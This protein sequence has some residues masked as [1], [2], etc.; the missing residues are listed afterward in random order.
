MAKRIYISS[1]WKSIHPYI[2][3]DIV[4]VAENVKKGT[5]LE[6][7]KLSRECTED[8]LS[9]QD[10]L[11]NQWLK[12][13]GL[14][15][16]PFKSDY[17]ICREESLLDKLWT[18]EIDIDDFLGYPKCCV[19]NHRQHGEKFLQYLDDK[20]H[21]TELP[22]PPGII[23]GHEVIKAIE[24]GNY[25]P[26]LNYVLHMPCSTY[27]KESIFFGQDIKKCLEE[28]DSDA[29]EYL[30]EFNKSNWKEFGKETEK[31]WHQFIQARKSKI[32][33]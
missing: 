13:S 25:N 12:N 22:L 19:R 2:R 30:K 33:E 16:R 17:Y 10:K 21:L 4:P 28:H 14:A 15:Y 9:E 3:T 23:L 5:Q 27:C 26:A 20:I 29:A 11:L 31:E 6:L 32:R 7:W 24:K 1:E 18:R 8:E